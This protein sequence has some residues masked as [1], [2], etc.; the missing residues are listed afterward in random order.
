MSGQPRLLCALGT[1]DM[2]IWKLGCPARCCGV[3]GWIVGTALFADLLLL[4]SL[5]VVAAGACMRRQM[6]YGQLHVVNQA[7]QLEMGEA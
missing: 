6:R 3:V 5:L 4:W 7:L 2:L 1:L